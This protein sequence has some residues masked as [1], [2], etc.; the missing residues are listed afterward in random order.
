MKRDKIPKL[1]LWINGDISWSQTKDLNY[2]AAA[3]VLFTHQEMAQTLY[4]FK[5]ACFF[6]LHKQRRKKKK[7]PFLFSRGILDKS[8]RISG[9]TVLV[10]PRGEHWDKGYN[11]ILYCEVININLFLIQN[12]SCAYYTKV[13]RITWNRNQDFHL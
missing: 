4:I 6:P 8:Y 13:E 9:M 3:H 11:T 12:I 2:Q 5:E 7:C 1:Y 10:L